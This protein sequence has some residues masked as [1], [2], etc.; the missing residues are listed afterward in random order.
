MFCAAAQ[1]SDN[2]GNSLLQLAAMK[3]RWVSGVEVGVH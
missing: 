1:A 3:G 2:S